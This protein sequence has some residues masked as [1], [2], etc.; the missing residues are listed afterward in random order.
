MESTL[1][2]Q[3]TNPPEVVTPRNTY[4]QLVR[5]S[6]G[7]EVIAVSG[8]LGVDAQGRLAD[9]FPGQVRQ[10]LSNV[11]AILA[12]AGVDLGQ[13]LHLRHY[14]VGSQDLAALNAERKALLGDEPPA[15]TLIVVSGLANPAALYEVDALAVR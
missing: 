9:D 12:G 2:R 8:Q 5:I 3:A 10:A 14:V 4:T 6:G 7:S 13:A 11:K 15:S 1:R